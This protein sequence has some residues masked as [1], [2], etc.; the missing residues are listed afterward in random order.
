[1]DGEEQAIVREHRWW[2]VADIVR[3]GD[4]FASRRLAE[5]LTSLLADG[6]PAIP[7]D[8]GV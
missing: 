8:A 4:E 7:R 6:P 3:S 2:T 1:M 5:L